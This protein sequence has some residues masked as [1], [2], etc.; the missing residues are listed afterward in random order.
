MLVCTKQIFQPNETE[1]GAMEEALVIGG[2]SDNW[3]VQSG[4][5]TYKARKAFSGGNLCRIGE[6]PPI[7]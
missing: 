1:T 6:L 7:D 3:I 2:G 4:S 5:G